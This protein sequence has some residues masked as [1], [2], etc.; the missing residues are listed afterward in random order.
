MRE[1]LGTLSDYFY[2]RDAAKFASRVAR[3]RFQLRQTTTAHRADQD[4]DN[5]LSRLL[6]AA[7]EDPAREF[8]E[9]EASL[10]ERTA[11]VIVGKAPD[12]TD[13]YL[14]AELSITIDKDDVNRA[15]ERAELLHRATGARTHV[16]VI[17]ESIDDDAAAH[18]EDR[19][20]AFTEF[21]R[22]GQKKRNHQPSQEDQ[23]FRQGPPSH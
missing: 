10:V 8:T 15:K 18:A 22:K 23:E 14:L 3:R 19:E 9:D 16:L 5:A 12:G 7:A 4:G 17:G 21:I 2:Q 13:V 1:E 6:D 20:V 11:A